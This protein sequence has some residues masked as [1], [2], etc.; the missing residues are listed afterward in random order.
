MSRPFRR[1]SFA[2]AERLGY[3]HPRLMYQDLTGN[4][5]MEWMAFDRTN[6]PDWLKEYNE[7]Q[8]IERTNNLSVEERTKIL[9]NMMRR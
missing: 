1:Y 5:V 3:A 4:E 9:K 6:N 2:L 7:A 8:E